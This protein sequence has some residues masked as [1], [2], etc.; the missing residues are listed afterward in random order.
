MPQP[1]P[2]RPSPP[3][4][5]RRTIARL[6]ALLFRMGLG[7][8]FGGRLLLLHH[9]GRATGSARQAVLE[10]VTHE[11]DIRSWTVAAGFGTRSDWYQNLRAEPKAVIQF[12]SRH[13]AVTAHFLAAEDGAAIMERYG[14][15]HPRTARRLCA[16]MRLAADGSDR[17]F[18]DAG[19]V[20][21]F[22]RLDDDG[23]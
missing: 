19:R 1:G 3:V 8:V 13:H 2:E 7:P 4:G 9:T 21:P 10:V 12:G 15:R 17:S 6:P 23:P 5:W 11:R 14:R 22:V 18:R 16:F 20:I